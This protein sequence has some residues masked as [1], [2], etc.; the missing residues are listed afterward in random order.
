[1][2]LAGSADVERPS[3][4]DKSD[5]Y[6]A[7]SDEEASGDQMELSPGTAVPWLFEVVND[8]HAYRIQ[9]ATGR[10]TV[11]LPTDH[12]VNRVLGDPLPESERPRHSGFKPRN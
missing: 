9:R 5:W 12:S 8:R 1:M 7:R 11:E 6:V 3:E 4:L 10:P 2:L